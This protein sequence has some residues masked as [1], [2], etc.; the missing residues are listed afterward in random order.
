[1]LEDAYFC[2]MLAGVERESKALSRVVSHYARKFD[3]SLITPIHLLPLYIALY[4]MLYL[5]TDFGVDHRVSVNEGILLSK[6]FCDESNK[7]LTNGVLHAVLLAPLEAKTYAESLTASARD[8]FHEESRSLSHPSAPLS[9]SFL[10]PSDTQI[11]RAKKRKFEID[12][13]SITQN[14]RS[15][16]P[17]NSHK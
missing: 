7:R 1:M 2:E 11:E 15:H 8:I 13:L 9:E 17:E 3:I 6:T 10:A 4:E 16:T 14:P 5:S 12:A